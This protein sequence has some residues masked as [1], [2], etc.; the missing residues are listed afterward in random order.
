MKTIA[1]LSKEMSWLSA[2]KFIMISLFIMLLC[3]FCGVFDHLVELNYFTEFRWSPGFDVARQVDLWKNNRMREYMPIVDELSFNSR[4]GNQTICQ[5]ANLLS[6]IIK[7][8]T[9]NFYHRT[10]WRKL[11]SNYA[12]DGKVSY[13]F[14]IHKTK[15][16]YDLREILEYEFENE[17]DTL[18]LM[19]PNDHTLK[20]SSM[21]TI[22]PLHWA[23]KFCHLSKYY[24]F[25]NDV[26]YYLLS[27]PKLI[28]FLSDLNEQQI[29]NLYAGIIKFTRVSR[30]RWNKEYVS[31][32]DYPF[33]H[34]PPY[35]AGNGP[36]IVS[37]RSLQTIFMASSYVMPFP[38]ED[39][40][41]G[42][43][44]KKLSIDPLHFNWIDH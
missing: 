37:N 2:I 25:V 44:A 28:S 12:D 13:H 23:A 1:D 14:A 39:R 15:N 17:K 40:Y 11:L 34:Y 18:H 24:L 20:F 22:I 26:D 19:V 7:T 4:S 31:L 10:I 5:T 43:I 30:S 42:I 32:S 36:L 3:N 16:D 6:I 41:F 29:N 27:I 33:S 8:K 38:L 9:S 35:I 21:T